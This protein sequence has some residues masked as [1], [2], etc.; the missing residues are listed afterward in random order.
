M[1][2][3]ESHHGNARTGLLVRFRRFEFPDGGRVYE[4]SVSDFAHE[5]ETIAAS[6][7]N[8]SLFPPVIRL[9]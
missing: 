9:P 4:E 8:P 6:Q 5:L 1:L 3:I 2:G 7:G